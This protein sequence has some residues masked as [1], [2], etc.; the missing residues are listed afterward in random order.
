MEAKPVVIPCAGS[1]IIGYYVVSPGTTQ[2]SS[3]RHHHSFFSRFYIVPQ[4]CA[5]VYGRPLWDSAWLGW[6]AGRVKS[7]PQ[8]PRA[9]RRLPTRHERFPTP[10]SANCLSCVLLSLYSL[11]WSP[12]L[13]LLESPFTS[14]L[15]FLLQFVCCSN[16]FYIMPDTSASF[17]LL[18]TSLLH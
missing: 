8:T 4:A 14:P 6:T 10:P 2:R 9:G 5:E 11:L 1:T 15:H 7:S 13:D 12:L 16:H 18:L 3:H 17:L